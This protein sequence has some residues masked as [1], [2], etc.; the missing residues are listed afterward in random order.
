[1][2]LGP[3]ICDPLSSVLSELLSLWW[4]KGLVW[5]YLSLTAFARECL[6]EDVC[7]AKER[8]GKDSL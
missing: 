4:T 6:S 8:D 1:M 7:C 5:Q 2:V 3:F